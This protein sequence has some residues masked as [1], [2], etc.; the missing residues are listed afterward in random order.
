MRADLTDLRLADRVFAPHYAEAQAQTA[1]AATPLLVAPGGIAVSELLPGD[2]FDLLEL[3]GGFAWGRSLTDGVVG[4]IDAGALGEPV[5]ATHIVSAREAALH[6]APDRNAAPLAALPMGSRIAALGERDAFLLTD[7]GY[8][9]A[10]AVRPIGE[11]DAAEVAAA[12]LRMIGASERAGGR[13]GAGVDAAGLVF[14]AHDVAGVAVPRLPD[15]I[16]AALT[17][18]GDAPAAGDVVVFADH[19]AIMVDAVSAVHVEGR[20]AR[21]R[22]STLAERHG[23]PVAY[24]RI[25]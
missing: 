20:V 6:E 11:A 13:S 24:G 2:A 15:L 19:L 3:S 10:E 18:G 23:A 21:E 4:Y 5:T 9:A 8:V 14:L 17:P 1:L 22:L 25:G 7:H 16:A 12:A